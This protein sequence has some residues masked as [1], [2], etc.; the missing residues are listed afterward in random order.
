M[1]TIIDIRAEL[2]RLKTE[3]L[4]R[5]PGIPRD[6]L[7]ER[8]NRC[9]EK[10]IDADIPEFIYYSCVRATEL[11][12]DLKRYNE[13][14]EYIKKAKELCGSTLPEHRWID[15]YVQEARA[16]AIEENWQQAVDVCDLGVAL[17]E[18]CR[19]KI[20]AP[21]V[22]SEYLQNKIKLYQIGAR[23]AY[24]LQN[25]AKA[26]E[27]A[28]LGKCF[29]GRLLANDPQNRTCRVDKVVQEFR[30]VCARLDDNQIPELLKN[31]LKAKRKRLQELIF[32]RRYKQAGDNI[33]SSHVADV[34]KSLLPE[35]AVF[36]YFWLGESELLIFQISFDM[37]NAELRILSEKEM[38]SIS[39]LPNTVL[40]YRAGC[41]RLLQPSRTHAKIL[42]PSTALDH[43]KSLNR[44]YISPHRALHLIPFHAL[45]VNNEFLIDFCS[46]NYI[47]NLNPL[48]VRYKP[49]DAPKCLCLGVRQSVVKSESGKLYNAIE[50]AIEEMKDIHKVYRAAEYL[51]EILPNEKATENTI[52]EKDK[53]GELATYSHL[54]FDCHG[55][56]A[57]SDFPQ[58]AG[59]LLYD[60]FF[61]G[62]DI[63]GLELNADIVVLSACNSGQ[64]PFLMPRIKYSETRRELPGDEIFGLQAAFY[65]AGARQIVSTLWPVVPVVARKISAAF[66]RACVAGMAADEALRQAICEYK[67]DP[68]PF[69]N[70]ADYWGS[71]FLSSL[72]LPDRTIK[73]KYHE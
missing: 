46:I 4:R 33:K 69:Y 42:L 9:L 48:R 50:N 68:D 19:K 47:A 53:T 27:F 15:L 71:F 35:E 10:S 37:I 7:L 45:P 40:N 21:S 52:R 59:L 73:E 36:Y 44:I 22:Q 23:A 5:G 6:D 56:A 38:E 34:Q 8:Y 72:M 55:M 1:T 58:D 66:H 11:L 41:G 2:D 26:L 60:S 32:V 25:F 28:D 49:V 3:H 64:R 63:A 39:L 57:D 17:V 30:Q 62:I 61:D 31:E 29:T 13:T 70:S 24:I 51:C 12:L 43:L 67:K 65:A 18:K 14:H 54:H 16:Y 20:T